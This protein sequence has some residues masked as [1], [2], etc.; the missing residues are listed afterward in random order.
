MVGRVLLLIGLAVSV[1]VACRLPSG[2]A[3]APQQREPRPAQESVG[4]RHVL[5]TRLRRLWPDDPE[6]P[7]W[8]GEDGYRVV[9]RTPG[10]FIAIRAPISTLSP[11]LAMSG[12]FHKAGGPPGGGYG[13][14]VRRQ[15][16]GA[17]DGLDQQGQFVVAAVGDRGEFG[18]WR[19]DGGRWLDLV[20][21]TPSTAVQGGDDSERAV[22]ARV[23]R[24]AHV[25][26][27]RRA[28]RRSARSG[29]K[30]AAWASTSAATSTKWS[31]TTWWSTS[32][33]LRAPSPSRIP[34]CHYRVRSGKWP[35]RAR[36]WR[37]SRRQAGP[38]RRRRM[39]RG[40]RTRPTRSRRCSAWARRS[41]SSTAA[42][43]SAQR[44]L[45]ACAT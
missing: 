18:V 37:R 3:A 28:G 19:R 25:Q 5:D 22:G 36:D 10:Q 7:A 21:W 35:R 39:R 38:R 11:D 13:L 17:G 1:T 2:V 14:I 43:R 41:S 30:R 45:R 24:A 44:R 12:T 9:A 6:G 29:C 15:P 33:R 27:Q 16:V 26:R 4:S 34:P 23:G 32:S 20:P 40:A 31:S 8:F 42:D